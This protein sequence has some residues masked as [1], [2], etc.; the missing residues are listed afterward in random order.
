MESEFL[1]EQEVAPMIHVAIKTLQDWRRKR[2]VLP[3][4][5]KRRNVYY[6]RED[7]EE[8]LQ[9]GRVEVKR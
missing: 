1:T 3:Y 2:V 9:T 6:K 7:I 5:K 8:Y 4:H